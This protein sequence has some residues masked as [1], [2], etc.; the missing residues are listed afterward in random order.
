MWQ[1]AI[2]VLAVT[3][4]DSG[5]RRLMMNLSKY[6]LPVPALPVKKRLC[7]CMTALRTLYC[8]SVKLFELSTRKDRTGEG[9][10]DLIIRFRVFGLLSFITSSTKWGIKTLNKAEYIKLQTKTTYYFQVFFSEKSSL[11]I[12][13]S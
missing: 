12:Q 2:P 6:D 10:I 4:V 7:P 13:A 1:A 8:S 5:G 9:M 3:K 11:K